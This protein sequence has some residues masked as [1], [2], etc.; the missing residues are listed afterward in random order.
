MPQVSP[1]RSEEVRDE[2]WC[3][4]GM[5][6][7]GLELEVGVNGWDQHISL[8]V[9]YALIHCGKVLDGELLHSLQLP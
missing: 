9:H 2:Q 6:K 7:T 1:Q 8:P 3:R 4:Q 5:M